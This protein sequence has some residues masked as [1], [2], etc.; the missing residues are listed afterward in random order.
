MK[1]MKKQGFTLIEL[2]VVM[3]VIAT[4]AAFTTT[5]LLGLQRHTHIST[6]LSTILAD[7]YGQRSKAMIGDTQGRS[8]IDSYGIYFQTG[9]YTLFHG[10]TYNATATDNV[11]IPIES[12][13]QVSSTTIPN[14]TVIFTKGSGEVSGFSST[15]N[16]I[17]FTNSSSNEQVT[18][19]F[20]QY[21]TIT[22]DLP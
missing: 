5:N 18:V 12:P 19:I 15:Q 10:T 14:S 20:N 6:T 4:L 2:I 16:S 21:G 1:V 17:S 9:Q 3:G 11:I 13:V 22:S 8:T 7:W